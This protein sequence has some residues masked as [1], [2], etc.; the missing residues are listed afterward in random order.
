MTTSTLTPAQTRQLDELAEIVRFHAPLAAFTGAGI[1]TESGIPDYRGP[2]GLW[3]TGSQ[4]PFTYEDF[5]SSPE[6]RRE[7]WRRLPDRLDNVE[8]RR[9]NAGHRALARIERAFVMLAVVTQNIDGL[10]QEAGSDPA[11]VIELHGS[12]RTIR[13]T[14]CGEVYLAREMLEVY[15]DSPEPP[16]H[17]TVYFRGRD[18]DMGVLTKYTVVEEEHVD[19]R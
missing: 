15:G 3:T 12:S 1:S 11:R 10:Q 16:P 7:W 19:A 8:S 14:Q 17:A 2:Q 18:P 6:T 5:M 4:K 13:C 9:P